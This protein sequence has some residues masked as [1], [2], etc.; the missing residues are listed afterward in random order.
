MFLR[1]GVRLRYPAWLGVILFGHTALLADTFVFDN[2]CGDNVWNTCCLLAGVNENN[3]DVPGIPPDCPPL[4]GPL[5]D[6]DIGSFSVVL[7]IS[8]AVTN[9]DIDGGALTGLGQLTFTGTFRGHG[10]VGIGFVGIDPLSVLQADVDGM[11]LQIDAPIPSDNFGRMQA[12]GGG[13]LNIQSEVL[14][15][16]SILADGGLAPSMTSEVI[17]GAPVTTGRVNTFCASLLVEEG[18][19]L[20]VEE[21]LT[22]D[23]PPSAF[24]G[25]CDPSPE[26]SMELMMNAQLQVGGSLVMLGEVGILVEAGVDVALAGDFDNQS[27]A[28]TMFAWEGVLRLT[29]DGT[30]QLFETASEDLGPVEEG[31][32]ENFAIGTLRVESGARVRFDDDFGA[33]GAGDDP[34]FYVGILSFGTGSMIENNADGVYVT[35]EDEGGTFECGAGASLV[36]QRLCQGD[37]NDDGILDPMD[38][39]FVVARFGM[40]ACGGDDDFNAADLNRD[41]RVNPLDA[42]FVRA[43]FSHICGGS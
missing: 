37:A 40:P 6:A 24:L 25:G 23:A 31:F 9:F 5:D 17:I 13:I 10:T 8:A 30:E 33:R 2:S 12:I 3:W 18:G 38:N 39:G 27:T 14:G 20:L 41:G 43:R 42:G 34:A 15:D 21:D 1:N 35:I 36:P 26:M 16:G 7:D 22:L 32:V 19:E 28:P 11:E 29:G 4:P